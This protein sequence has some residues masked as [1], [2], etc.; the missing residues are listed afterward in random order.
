MKK[1]LWP[2][3]LL[4]CMT[5]CQRSSSQAWEDVKT[6]GR[7]VQQGFKTL[8]GS[9]TESRQIVSK[10]EFTGPE[11]DDF[12]ALEEKDL[13]SQYTSSDIALAQPKEN[14]DQLPSFLSPKESKYQSIH[15]DTD[16]HVIRD[17]QDL[18]TVDKIANF[19]KKNPKSYLKIE[20]HCDVRA[21]SA[22]NMALGM[23][24]ANH[25]RVL[26]IKKGIDFNRIY[27]VS[28]GKE[29]VL[30]QG[31]NKEAHQKNRRSEFKFFTKD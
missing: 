1:I 27:T 2:L 9:N 31:N 28:F 29:K 4:I 30:A 6:A 20:G 12:I 17:K 22:Y 14:K 24:R 25:I 5:S 8:V 26:L 21:S 18:I 16:D 7:Y 3:S 10:D 19:L 13:H 11:N 23:R 15:F